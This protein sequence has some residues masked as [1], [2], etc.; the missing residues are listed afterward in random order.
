MKENR[1]AKELS[2]VEKYLARAQERV[3]KR[4][5]KSDLIVNFISKE[6]ELEVLSALK[7][8]CEERLREFET[9]I[10]QDTEILKNEEL[11]FNEVNCV[12]LRLGEKE[13]LKFFIDFSKSI[14]KLMELSANVNLFLKRIWWVFVIIFHIAVM[15]VILK[16]LFCIIL[17]NKVEIIFGLN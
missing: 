12:G 11:S 15:L 6:N 1:E 17:S 14:P 5:G 8:A 13:I 10:E 16:N 4:K 7:L 9:T 2:K 3:N